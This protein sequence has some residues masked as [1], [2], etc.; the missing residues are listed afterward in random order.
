MKTSID[1][2]LALLNR[3]NTSISYL[4]QII[5]KDRRTLTGWL[6]KGIEP[7]YD[8]KKKICDFFRY[9]YSIWDCDDNEFA[10]MLE[11]LPTQEINI[12]DKGYEGALSY[13]LEQEKTS[14]FVIQPRFPGP[15][16]RD[17]VAK[18]PYKA[19]TS[20][21]AKRLRMERSKRILDY[22]FVSHEWYS[23]ESLLRFAFSPIGNFFT[24]KQKILI[25]QTVY[26]TFH[27]NYNKHLYLFD[28]HATKV[29]GMDTIY[30]SINKDKGIMFFKMPI[31]SL[32]VEVSNKA[33]VDKMFKHFSSKQQTPNHI[34]PFYSPQ[35]IQM[36]LESLQNDESLLD[37]YCKIN[38]NT[39]FGKLFANQ[40][41]PESLNS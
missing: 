27:D 33:L 26:E 19:S 25:L 39:S 18:S 38:N 22:S 6:E 37:F 41:A 36:I 21:E 29:F 35:I 1:K 8:A 20:E 7:S 5:G 11:S 4:S 16:Y 30:I 2:I 31:D 34:P 3:Y 40:I 28:S 10:I 14:R 9:P 24:K 13:I 12:I 17:F 32:I 23:L 15:T